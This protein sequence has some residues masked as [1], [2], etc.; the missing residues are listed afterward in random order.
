MALVAFLK[1]AGCGASPRT[2]RL[3][4]LWLWEVRG[5]GGEGRWRGEV[6]VHE[7]SSLT[8]ISAGPRRIAMRCSSRCSI[9]G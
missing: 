1:G 3:A 2:V 9:E 8:V 4:W 5:R 6:S 7:M